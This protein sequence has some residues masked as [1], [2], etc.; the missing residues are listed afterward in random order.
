MF[1]RTIHR[2]VAVLATAG[3]GAALAFIPSG[4]ALAAVQGQYGAEAQADATY[5]GSGGGSCD[6]TSG[7]DSVTTTPVAFTHGTKHQSVSLDAT[8][9][10]S[11]DSSDQ[12]TVAGH[13]TSSLTLKRK[14]GDLKS[15][16]MT[17]GGSVTISHTIVGSQCR[18]S[19]QL[20]AASQVM[21]T[22]H[23]KGVLTLTRDT[24]KAGS[25]ATFVLVNLDTDRAIAID[26]FEG[27]HS[28]N[29]AHLKLKPG[30]YEIADNQLGV[31][32]GQGMLL[33]SGQRSAK[34]AQTIHLTASFA[35]KKG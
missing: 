13:A 35:P 15:F 30:N 34:V 26:A 5:T 1:T 8:F 4:S 29:V 9:T 10:N 6:L 12:V 18:G 28:H 16:D 32:A 7:L 17:V 24:K 11:L 31:F 3:L 25:L 19:G 21:F 33:K 14:A 20:T 2:S 27:S 23:K 22:E